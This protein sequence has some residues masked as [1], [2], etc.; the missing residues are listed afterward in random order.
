MQ[1]KM[2][3]NCSSLTLYQAAEGGV[4]WALRAKSVSV[5]SSLFAGNNAK[6][7]SGVLCLN[8]KSYATVFLSTFIGN[9]ARHRGGVIYAGDSSVAVYDSNFTSNVGSE[10]GGV[11]YGNSKSKIVVYTSCFDGNKAGWDGGVIQVRHCSVAFHASVF[12]QSRGAR[13]VAWWWSCV[14]G[15]E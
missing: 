13:M 2:F 15:G 10:Y 1:R 11:L 7:F 8:M 6:Q 5:N 9:T 3:F 12:S 4:V 14:H